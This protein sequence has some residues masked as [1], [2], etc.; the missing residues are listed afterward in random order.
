MSLNTVTTADKKR[1][2]A[3]TNGTI[4]LDVFT[5]VIFLL[6][7]SLFEYSL[8]QFAQRQQQDELERH[9][10]NANSVRRLLE[11]EITTA[12]SLATGIES[13]IVARR[14][15]IL[16]A[17]IEPMMALIYERS[18]LFRNI[19][20]APGNRIQY[21]FPL[22]GNQSAL[23]MSYEDNPKQWPSVKKAMESRKGLLVGPVSLVQGG[24]G[25]IYRQPVFIGNDY[26]GMMSTV[27]DADRLF[28][29]LDPL[30]GDGDLV[31]GLRA[32]DAQGQL[33]EVF[34]GTASAFDMNP[35]LLTINIPGASWQL[36]VAHKPVPGIGNWLLRIA[37]WIVALVLV[38]LFRLLVRLQW[39]NTTMEKLEA[40]VSERTQKLEDVNGLLQS[41]LNAASE[42]AI[43][44][45][46]TQG[47]I[48]LFNSGAQRM[49][50]YQA[51]Q[52]VGRNTP[53]ILHR[54]DELSRRAS[55]LQHEYG[56]PVSGFQ[57]LSYRVQKVGHDLSE[58][59]YV[60]KDGTELPVLLRATAIRGADGALTGYLFLAEDIAERKRVERMKSE[61]ISTVSHELR[62]PLT[63]ISG[64]LGLATGGALGEVTGRMR[65]MLVMAHKN[66]QSLI[67]LI[68]DLL[69]MEKLVAG[70]MRFDMQTQPLRPLLA[71]ALKDNQ[72]YASQFGV[73][74]ELEQYGDD[75]D[76]TVDAHRVQQVMANLL[77]NAAKFSPPEGVVTM[78]VSRQQ[79]LVRVMVRDHGAGIPVQFQSRIFEK[80]AQADS[81]DSREK[82]G[83]GLGLAITREL[84]ERMGGTV[85]FDSIEGEGATFWFELPVVG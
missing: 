40:M 10:E 42:V 28:R 38:S 44:A 52:V 78:S 72:M 21:L 35:S 85:G 49:L 34:S 58:W 6:L 65:D 2:S 71:Q 9:L 74:L 19:G 81:S 67:L 13:Y 1:L 61:F 23:G 51:A 17:D 41:V 43:I 48:T 25:L 26:W 62:T 68:N 3:N 12:A 80:F 7:I 46:D 27:L 77:S 45:T 20:L 16:A 73:R 50:G 82:G 83:T 8:H 76:V 18:S 15:E 53:E 75:A 55:A 56:E 57:T 4:W 14:G 70:E 47:I 60:R 5:V 37:G 84:V 64:A 79:D 69:D 36:A 54:S 11:S 32:V 22:E 63:V 33:G 31:F 39:Q 24:L 30:A 29:L 66:S 59:I